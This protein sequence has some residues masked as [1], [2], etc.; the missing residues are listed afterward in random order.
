M[1]FSKALSL[2]VKLQDIDLEL[3]EIPFNIFLKNTCYT[4]LY[5]YIQDIKSGEI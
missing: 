1:N 3:S 5:E 4:N 2:A